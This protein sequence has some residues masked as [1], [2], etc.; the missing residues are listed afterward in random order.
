M[1]VLYED[2]AGQIWA[3]TDGGLSRL[4]EANGKAQLE[5]VALGVPS[6]PDHALQIWAIAE[7][8][9]GSLWMG[10]SW[11][12]VGAETMGGRPTRHPAAARLRPRADRA[13]RSPEQALDWSRHGLDRLPSRRR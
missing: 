6:R 10:T 1:N 3:G 9:N 11:G 2:R 7:D 4:S 8:L 13:T 5:R 12:L